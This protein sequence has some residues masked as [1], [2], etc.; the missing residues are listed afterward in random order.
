MQQHNY[1]Y[2]WFLFLAGIFLWMPVK[3][4]KA[5]Q[6]VSKGDTLIVGWQDPTTMAPAVNALRNT[7][8]GDTTSSGARAHKVYELKQGGVYWITDQIDNSNFKLVVVG[9]KPNYSSNA[10][11][12]E[13]PAVIQMV[14]DPKTGTA[15]SG[16]IFAGQSSLTVK[17]VWI[18]GCDDAGTMTYYLPDQLAGS[19]QRY[20]FDHDIF[21]RTNFSMVAFNGSNN[22]VYIT[23]CIFR[24]QVGKPSNQQ[25]Q[26]RGVMFSASQ[27]TIV[28]QNNTFFNMQYTAFQLEGGYSKYTLFNHNTIVNMGRQIENNNKFHEYD[29]N[30]LLINPFW[31]GEGHADYTAPGRPADQYSTGIF[32]VGQL[33]AA[34]GLEQERRIVIAHNYAWRDPIFS[35]QQNYADTIHPQPFLSDT[36]RTWTNAYSHMVVKDTVWLPSAPAGMTADAY[37]GAIADSMWQ[38]ITDLRRGLTPAKSY[39]YKLPGGQ[40]PIGLSTGI[41]WTNI[42]WPLPESFAYTTDSLKTAGTDGL[43]IG[44]LN[45]FPTAMQNFQANKSTYIKQIEDMAGS[46]VSFK[47]LSMLQAENGSLGGDAKV[48]TAKGTLYYTMNGSGYIKW[49]FNLSQ[50][51]TYGLKV[52]TRSQS[53]P[54]GEYIFINGSKNSITK[55]DDSGYL[56]K[57]LTYPDWKTYTITADSL[58]AATAGQ[59]NFVQGMD[60]IKITPEWGYQDFSEIDIFNPSNNKIIKKLTAP[61][62][63]TSVVSP[64]AVSSTDPSKALTNVPSGFMDVEIGATG[65]AGSITWN[66]D[67]LANGTYVARIFYHTAG[68]ATTGAL[69][70][71]GQQAASLNFT[72]SSMSSITTPPITINNGQVTTQ[73]NST[74]KLSSSGHVYIDYIQLAQQTSTPTAIQKTPQMPNGY[75]LDQNY[76]NPFNPTTNIKFQIPKASHVKLTVYNILG[77]RVATLVDNQLSAGIHMV[78]FHADKLASG[79]YF[80]RLRAGNFVASKKLLLLK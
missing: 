5:Q 76:P 9:Q 77:Q 62:A 48:D 44:N 55:G 36:S 61:M 73:S 50:A 34:Y 20:I 46:R 17:N 47:I 59:L 38:N 51:G 30:N 21:S 41:N 11:R 45:Y 53:D 32:T 71:N 10:T 25:W 74:L 54:R 70:V 6:N 26:G 75:K 66:T 24:N 28:I 15:P 13:G 69:T 49:V 12:A 67:S 80:Y 4:A 23:N 60:S 40:N 42:N 64:G 78:Q 39:F 35:I 22:D 29:T 7:I 43:P 3:Q 31:Q 14:T 68:S 63:E 79:V 33:P 65:K 57:G 18:I 58:T 37:S 1:R 16:H 19:G 27:D 52:I 72:S 2:L 56:F 8:A